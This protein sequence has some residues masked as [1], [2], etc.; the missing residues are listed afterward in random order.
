MEGAPVHYN[1]LFDE[2]QCIGKDGTLSHGPN[3]VISMFDH[4]LKED[5]YGEQRAEFHADNC[6]GTV[7]IAINSM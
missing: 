4:Y 2:S 6:A 7:P 3:A 5:G 1:Y